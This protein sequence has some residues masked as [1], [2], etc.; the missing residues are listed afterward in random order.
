MCKPSRTQQC[1]KNA[2]Y[3]PTCG[4]I[5]VTMANWCVVQHSFARGASEFRACRRLGHRAGG[6]HHFCFAHL[7]RGSCAHLPCTNGQ[8][9]LQVRLTSSHCMTTFLPGCANPNVMYT[10]TRSTVA[11][12]RPIV[13]STGSATRFRVAA[14]VSHDAP[15]A[16]FSD[17][18]AVAARTTSCLIY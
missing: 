10:M 14:H 4:T 16:D 17:C 15:L 18:L 8:S 12:L 5:K 11:P 13:H 7:L 9:L 3:N 2:R 1:Q 6:A